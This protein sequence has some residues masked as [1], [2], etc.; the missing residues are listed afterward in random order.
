MTEKQI[1]TLVDIILE[2]ANLTV[3]EHSD[4]MKHLNVMLY[5]IKNGD[6][7]LG[8]F[9]LHVNS[10]DSLFTFLTEFIERNGFV[11]MLNEKDMRSVVK[12][13]YKKMV[14]LLGSNI[15][16]RIYPQDLVFYDRNKTGYVFK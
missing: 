6:V 3:E 1:N 8:Y 16:K 15:P 2:D 5:L 14:S 10:G 12:G 9:L 7:V 4:N 11:N 13:V